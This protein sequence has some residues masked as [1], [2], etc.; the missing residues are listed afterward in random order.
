[1]IISYIIVP[2]VLIVGNALACVW[3]LKLK[4][5]FNYKDLLDDRLYDK[6]DKFPDVAYGLFDNCYYET[7]ID[8]ILD[9]NPK[10]II[11]K[12]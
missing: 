1:M 8:Y 9:R 6:T 7:A 12:Q 11:K 10:P 3:N 2:I 5:H 4:W